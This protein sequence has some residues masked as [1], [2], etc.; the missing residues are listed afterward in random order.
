MSGGPVSL[1]A[2]T[3][4]WPLTRTRALHA[5]DRP[6]S[7]SVAYLNRCVV[8]AG[9]EWLR[10]FRSLRGRPGLSGSAAWWPV[11]RWL[12]GRSTG[13]DSGRSVFSGAPPTR[14]GSREHS[15]G[16]WSEA[17]DHRV[18]GP[19]RDRSGEA[20]RR[21]GPAR[22]A[23]GRARCGSSGGRACARSSSRRGCGRARGPSG[24]GSRRGR[25]WRAGTPI[26]RLR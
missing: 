12:M 5:P 26:G 24:R 23:R 18:V 1:A 11:T 4:G 19:R 15:V 20:V 2:D 9:G 17:W 3:A 7:P 14:G 6:P 21:R 25:G 16:S 10:G 22:R 8:K 13:D